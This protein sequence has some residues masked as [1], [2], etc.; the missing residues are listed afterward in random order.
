[1]H[2]NLGKCNGL[3]F[4]GMVG[5]CPVCSKPRIIDRTE[6]A[7]FKGFGTIEMVWERKGR[8]K[9]TNSLRVKFYGKEEEYKF[10]TFADAWDFM[11]NAINQKKI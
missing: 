9:E 8:T 1:M 10:N 6:T 4:G 7:K 11:A 2:E 5:G 3:G